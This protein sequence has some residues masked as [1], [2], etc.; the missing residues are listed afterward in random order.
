MKQVKKL[1]V[2]KVV[3]GILKA[4]Q[5]TPTPKIFISRAGF[6]F[7]LYRNG[8]GEYG[9]IESISGNCV[10][11]VSKNKEEVIR[12]AN[13]CF[14]EISDEVVRN[15]ICKSIEKNG[16][17]EGYHMNHIP[18]LV[19]QKGKIANLLIKK[20]QNHIERVKL[21]EPDPFM[22]DWGT[23]YPNKPLKDSI[24]QRDRVGL[25]ILKENQ[26]DCL[27][28][29]EVKSLNVQAKYLIDYLKPDFKENDIIVCNQREG[30]VLAISGYDWYND[31]F[32]YSVDFEG[33]LRECTGDLCIKTIN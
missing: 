15:G 9:I 19:Q 31:T 4:V 33:D 26:F 12:I 2:F 3:E 32:W 7:Y 18:I 28:D 13:N 14:D 23:S 30:V 11:Y 10:G 16:F 5:I 6:D 22:M 21:I 8:Y 17:V 25:E 29:D 20:Y 27:F 1:S 24:F